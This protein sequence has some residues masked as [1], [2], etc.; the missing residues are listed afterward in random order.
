MTHPYPL[1]GLAAVPTPA[2]VFYPA[3]I[4]RNIA[5]TVAR[6]GGPGRLRPH[7]KTH[8]TPEV[9]RLLREA[10]VTKHK[11]ATPAEA[12][13]LAAAGAADVLVAYPLVG[14]NPAR[15]AT[16]AA[17]F[18]ATRFAATIDRGP[19]ALALSAAATAAGVTLG[20]Y[21]DLDV[22]T[23]RTGVPA[24]AAAASLY[25]SAAGLPGLTACGLH[26]Y[27]GHNRQ[28]A[29]A[30][31]EAAARHGLMP[32]LEVR[33]EL[34]RRGHPVAGLVAGGSPTFPAHAAM[35]AI[36]GLECSPGTFVLHDHGYGSR[37]PDYEGLTPAAVL[38]T[39]VVSRPRADRVT[40]DLGTKAVAAD[41]PRA[42]RV[43][44]VDAPPHTVV[45]HGEE[46]LVIE[47]ADA[48]RYTP[49][50]V[51]YALPGHVC[52]TVALYDTALV[53]DGGRV[54]GAWRVERGR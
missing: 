8:K 44:L 29:P 26:A 16:L 17:R 28:P 48:G 9:V 54:V 19:A 37:F 4:R 41:P 12:E 31:R 18:P 5:V 30:D 47:T 51:C 39:R 43:H 33:A 50:D 32:V 36:D 20:F 22:G 38:L 1:A 53:A 45:M 52:P 13:M 15:L 34:R 42:D 40:F 24:D 6:A 7:A 11:C 46:H 35:H 10:G 25:E 23:G 27:D 14:P 49:G 3:L 21:L 2:L